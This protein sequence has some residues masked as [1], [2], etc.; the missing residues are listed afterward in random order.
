MKKK[1][2]AI[3]VTMNLLAHVCGMSH[4][5]RTFERECQ[6]AGF[7]GFSSNC[8]NV[9][10]NG[11]GEPTG[12]LVRAWGVRIAKTMLIPVIPVYPHDDVDGREQ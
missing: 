12:L 8:V 4:E 10:R 7:G 3:T 6:D 1:P 11:N 5:F 2:D 9:V